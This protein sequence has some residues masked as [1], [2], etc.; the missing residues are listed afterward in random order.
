MF[1]WVESWDFIAIFMTLSSLA[2]MFIG[3][4]YAQTEAEKSDVVK[5]TIAPAV[6]GIGYVIL[7]YY[8]ATH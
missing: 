8:V 7:H 4:R 6:A 5:R 2:M 3:R 1:S